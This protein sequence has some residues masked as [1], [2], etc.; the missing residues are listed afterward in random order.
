MPDPNK[1][2]ECYC[3]ADLSGLWNKAFAQVDPSTSKSRSGWIIFYAGCPVSW[4][5]KLQSQVAMSTTEAEYI[6]MSQ[7]LQDVILIMGLLQEMRELD[8]KVLCTEPYVYCKVFKDN[9]GT[10][11]LVRLSKHCPR[12]KYINVCYHHFV[13]MCERCLSK[14]SLLTP[15]NRLLMLSPSPWHKM[16]FHIIIASCAASDPHKLPK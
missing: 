12:T 9:S 1:G 8:F 3:D 6:A 13:N 11:E 16:T 14:Y 2:F 4:A 15:R 7:A 10:L 5:S